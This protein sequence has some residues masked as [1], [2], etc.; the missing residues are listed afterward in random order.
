VVDPLGT[1]RRAAHLLGLSQGGARLS[2]LPSGSL[3]LSSLDRSDTAA[4]S[5]QEKRRR[6][7]EAGGERTEETYR[8]GVPACSSLSRN[9]RDR[10]TA[11][12]WELEWSEINR[13][14]KR[15]G[16]RS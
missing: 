9:T 10:L 2:P 15:V 13:F 11:F 3:S 16:E 8:G 6:T 1:R 4:A 14:H 7:R 5:E 12:V